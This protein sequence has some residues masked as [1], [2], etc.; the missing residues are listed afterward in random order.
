MQSSRHVYKGASVIVES[1]SD[2]ERAGADF[3]LIHP[4]GN[5]AQLCRTGC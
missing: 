5:R 1:I 4:A 2:G 3:A